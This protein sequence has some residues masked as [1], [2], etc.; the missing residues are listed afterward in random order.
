LSRSVSSNGTKNFDKGCR[1]VCNR[2]IYLG[3]FALEAPNAF[4]NHHLIY[5]CLENPINS[6]IVKDELQRGLTN[7]LIGRLFGKYFSLERLAVY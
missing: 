2:Q 5:S 6:T 3:H 1:L 7:T 4:D